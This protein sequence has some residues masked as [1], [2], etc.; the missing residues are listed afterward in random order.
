[1]ESADGDEKIRKV[2]RKS[3]KKVTRK[4]GSVSKK[5]DSDSNGSNSLQRTSRLA[6]AEGSGEMKNAQAEDEVP[7]PK[8]NVSTDAAVPNEGVNPVIGIPCNTKT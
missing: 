7:N 2:T 1:M 5:I 4:A 8:A 3:S 6:S